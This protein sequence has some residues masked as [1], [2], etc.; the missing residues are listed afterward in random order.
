[1]R[2]KSGVFLLV[3]LTAMLAFTAWALGEGIYLGKSG[4]VEKDGG[5]YYG[6]SKGKAVT[7]QW[8]L[9]EKFYF[10]DDTGRLQTGWVKLEN[11][12]WNYFFSPTG[13]GHWGSSAIHAGWRYADESGTILMTLEG[14]KK[15]KI[16]SEVDYLPEG[17]F[18]GITRDFVVE[19]KPGSYAEKLARQ[20][21]LPY[22]NGRKKVLGTDITDVNRK[23]EWIIANYITSGMSQREKALVLHNWLIYNAH[24]DYTYSNYNADGVLV[25][26]T[27]VCDSYAKA[28]SLLLTM[29]GIENK[30]V[31]GE[32]NGGGHAWNVVQIDGQWYFVDVTWDDPN[33]SGEASV[34]GFE[35]SSYF[36]VNDATIRK[37][38]TLD[39]EILADSNQVGWIDMGDERYYYGADGK[40]ATGLTTIDRIEYEYDW[41]TD[42]FN[43]KTV[44]RQYYF[45]AD[46]IMQTGIQAIEGKRYYFA[47]DG[48]M[49][50]ACWIQP[51]RSPNYSYSFPPTEISDDPVYYL[52]EDGAMATGRVIMK[53]EEREYFYE[54]GWETTEVAYLYVF[55]K[56]GKLKRS[57][58]LDTKLMIP[59]GVTRIES[60]AF[61]DLGI[62]V[63]ILISE[64]VE[65]ISDDAFSGSNVAIETP[66]GSA[67]EEWGL[68]HGLVV[69]TR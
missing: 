63:L 58:P 68:A 1:M 18:E 64:K 29:V 3:L 44:P 65:F 36:L 35:R 33:D 50:K 69:I 21:G 43:T 66:A 40:R 45:S 48:T 52:G 34:S 4:W 10:F 28:Y 67:A 60:E 6:D 13:I 5:K 32:G 57:G 62:P 37:N 46:G 22:N 24:Y 11:E 8:K 7:G 14:L 17:F 26:G 47:K 27:G 39:E 56:T 59:A 51:D 23:A 15:L 41:E 16:P 2:R 19:C 9:D 55:D 30:R 31:T 20:L 25:E 61:A 54:T 42:E 12:Y 49:M 38:H 53:K